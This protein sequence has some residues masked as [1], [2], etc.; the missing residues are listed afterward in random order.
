L[1][2][3]T[4]YA[5]FVNSVLM[6]F[7]PS[8]TPDHLA[9]TPIGQLIRVFIYTQRLLFAWCLLLRMPRLGFSGEV[10]SVHLLSYNK[11]SL[12]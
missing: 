8:I 1:S 12:N 10:N 4:L 9:Q 5:E 6:R 3:A 2:S 7:C 11:S